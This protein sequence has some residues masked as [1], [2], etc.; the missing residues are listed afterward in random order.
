MSTNSVVW[1]TG[2]VISESG[3]PRKNAEVSGV[4]LSGGRKL[5]RAWSQTDY[6][7]QYFLSFEAEDE[8][9]SEARLT[10][11]LSAQS[12]GQTIESGHVEL[13]LGIER[14]AERDIRLGHSQPAMPKAA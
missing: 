14:E 8:P 3:Y 2:T 4:L 10:V 5:G 1:V 13:E 7:G 12:I 11:E 9:A 6:S